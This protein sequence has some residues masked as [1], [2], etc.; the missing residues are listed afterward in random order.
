M[1][2]WWLGLAVGALVALAPC[3]QAQD[4]NAALAAYNCGT[5]SPPPAVPH[6][7]RATPE[8]MQTFAARAQAWQTEQQAIV[9]CLAAAQTAMDQRTAALVDEYTQRSSQG[10]QAAAAWQ[11]A[12]GGHQ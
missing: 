8:Q 10:T 7:Q 6:G 5:P 3:A 1:R 9:R 11:A 4:A 2:R 12:A